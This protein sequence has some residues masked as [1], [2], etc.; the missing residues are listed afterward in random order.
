MPADLAVARA[1][2]KFS[3]WIL[4][5]FSLSRSILFF[6]I[7]RF[8]STKSILAIRSCFASSITFLLTKLIYSFKT[9]CAS[10]E[11]PAV[12]LTFIP[13][14]LGSFFTSG[15]EIIKFFSI[16]LDNSFNF[17]SCVSTILLAY[18]LNQADWAKN[19]SFVLR[20]S[21]SVLNW[22][23]KSTAT[24]SREKSLMSKIEAYS[25]FTRI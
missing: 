9:D 12:K 5:M 2:A 25:F 15:K 3:N 18:S 19:A 11:V 20:E 1:V 7:S 13:N 6:W 21:N 17:A 4:R 24:F 10:D 16:K 23:N 8:F 22:L 14:A